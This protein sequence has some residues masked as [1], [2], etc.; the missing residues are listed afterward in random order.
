M[1][2]AT[3]LIIESTFFSARI[4]VSQAKVFLKHP[5]A[6]A[7]E[8]AEAKRN[9]IERRLDVGKNGKHPGKHAVQTSCRLAK[10]WKKQ[11]P[12]AVVSS[13]TCENGTVV[14]SA[15]HVAD[16]LATG[17]APTFS[18]RGTMHEGA[19]HYLQH[20]KKWREA[21]LISPPTKLCI[22][23][24][25]LV[26][27]SL[28]TAAGPDGTCYASWAVLLDIAVD[29]IFDCNMY[30]FDGRFLGFT[31][32]EQLVIFVPK[33]SCDNPSPKA[34]DT[35]PLGLKNAL[36]KILAYI[37]VRQFRQVLFKRVTRIQRGFIGGRNFV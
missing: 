32:N 25:L 22:R 15:V 4:M 16:A 37:N 13:I 18:Q 12:T 33:A 36:I 20:C 31:L 34:L 17:W 1:E 11:F 27:A 19:E 8:F 14:N 35:R 26:L 6:F 29:L 28:S 2:L 23:R 9:S 5:E 30:L 24:F 3:R 7:T 21:G 10:L